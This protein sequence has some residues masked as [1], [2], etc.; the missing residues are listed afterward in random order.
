M[1][2]CIQNNPLVIN[3]LANHGMRKIKIFVF[4]IRNDTFLFNE[5]YSD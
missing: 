4:L 2:E 1:I 3:Q 5:Q